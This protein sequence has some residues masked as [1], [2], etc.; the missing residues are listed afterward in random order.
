MLHRII[1]HCHNRMTHC[2]VV[3]RYST[4]RVTYDRTVLPLL[5]EEVVVAVVAVVVVVVVVVVVIYFS[6]HFGSGDTF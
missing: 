3:V 2:Q 5:E 1:P 4:R 6:M